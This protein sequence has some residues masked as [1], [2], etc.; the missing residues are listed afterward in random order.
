MRTAI[1][2]A[3]AVV[4]MVECLP[5]PS[6]AA[7]YYPWCALL[8]NKEGGQRSCFFLTRDQC[9]ASL[10]VNG[11]YCYENP[12]PRSF[13]QSSAVP[14]SSAPPPRGPASSKKKSSTAGLQ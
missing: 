3:T 14:P 6:A 1:L 10:T 11:G 7:V 2:V 9:R 13:Y 5:R 12:N 8:E 4:I